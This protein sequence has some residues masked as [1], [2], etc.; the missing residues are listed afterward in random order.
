MLRID[1]SPIGTALLENICSGCAGREHVIRIRV[2]ISIL[3]TGQYTMNYS[4]YFVDSFG[5]NVGAD[6]V[7]GLY[8]DV[9]ANENISWNN[10][11]WGDI[12]FPRAEVVRIEG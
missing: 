6:C 7:H 8:F 4:F 9:I 12:H 2:N 11:S 10:K 3:A 1:R 5:N